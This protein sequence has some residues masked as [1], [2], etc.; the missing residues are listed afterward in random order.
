M[1]ILYDIVLYLI[2]IFFCFII[3]Y[4]YSSDIFKNG[5]KESY[6]QYVDNISP[7][8]F[9]LSNNI[10]DIPIGYAKK[11]NNNKKSPNNWYET[12][13]QD[14]NDKDVIDKDKKRQKLQDKKNPCQM[15]KA[16]KLTM[17]S[18]NKITGE[19]SA[20][21]VA[22]LGYC[23]RDNLDDSKKKKANSLKIQSND[24]AKSQAK[25]DNEK[26]KTATQKT[27][28]IRSGISGLLD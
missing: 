9:S 28:L 27:K 1:N 25:Q 11:E 7:I 10:P 8:S 2:L 22:N 16:E 15:F 18:D 21:M 26:Y 23:K 12:A 20:K 6:K 14:E 19:D 17:L 13:D 5:V 3:I 24:S 4:N